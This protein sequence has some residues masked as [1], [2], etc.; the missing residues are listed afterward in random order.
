M[1][2]KVH[3][4]PRDCLPEPSGEHRCTYRTRGM[5]PDRADEDPE[6][7]PREKT[8]CFPSGSFRAD[9]SSAGLSRYYS[10]TLQ[11]FP[12]DKGCWP[13]VCRQEVKSI[14]S[15]FPDTVPPAREHNAVPPDIHRYGFSSAPHVRIH[16]RVRETLSRRKSHI[17]AVQLP[18]KKRRLWRLWAE[19]GLSQ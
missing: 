11:E 12:I 3:K 7:W 10:G 1:R 18:M 16:R 9:R 4:F 17:E 19:S 2:R 15:I 5:A 13:G 14:L 8:V 6:S